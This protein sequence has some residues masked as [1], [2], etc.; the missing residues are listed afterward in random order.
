MIISHK[1]RFIFIKTRK[2]AG[3]SIEISLARYCGPDDI[4]TPI[5]L[6]DEPLRGRFGFSAQNYYSNSSLRAPSPLVKPTKR[7]I[8]RL[9]SELEI[10]RRSTIPFR[11]RRWLSNHATAS[12][13]QAE[14][15][16]NHIPASSVIDLVG[17]E[18]WNSYFC[19]CIERDPIA[20][21]ISD[22]RYRASHKSFD[23]YFEENGLPSDWDK[24]THDDNIIVNYV[25]RF[26]TLSRDLTTAL[27]H[28]GI[29]FDGWLPRAKQGN[30][31]DAT[32]IDLSAEQKALIRRYFCKEYAEFEYD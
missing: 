24:Y 23:S 8:L 1:H 3:T 28:V 20:K 12:S 5:T 18:I 2:T 31:S 29:T 6:A 21:T 26:E 32:L 19:F 11:L 10:K 7:L 17:E 13:L 14:H 25:G 16:Y 9:S 22:Y 30:R 27:A 15:Y 4:I